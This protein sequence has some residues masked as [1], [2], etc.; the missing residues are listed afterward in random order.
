MN[1]NIK[2]YIEKIVDDGDS[3]E[4]HM[5]SKMLDETI[6]ALKD[7]D[8]DMYCEYKTKLYEMAYGK[9][10]SMEMADKWIKNMTP[11]ARWSKEETD[12]VVD[13]YNLKM[14]KI[15][16]WALL[17]MLYTDYGKVINEFVS[18]DEEI[19]FYVKMAMAWWN[20]PDAKE[21]GEERLYDR[22]KKYI[23]A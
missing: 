6:Y 4:M 18:D 9:V 8:Y 19:D 12:S 17:N 5:L 2:E 7:Y 14:N 22:A 20:D 21:T 15:C 11:T 1:N 23:G 16:A 13:N 10:L 3:K